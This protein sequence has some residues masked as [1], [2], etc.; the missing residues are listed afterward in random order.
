MHIGG[1]FHRAG[2]VVEGADDPGADD[3]EGQQQSQPE[4]AGEDQRRGEDI[5]L[6]PGK[7]GVEGVIETDG[8][9]HGILRHQMAAGAVCAAKI[10]LG[11]QRTGHH[12]PA[13]HAV[14]HH[15]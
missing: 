10:L 6:D 13:V 15:L 11:Q 9:E 3:P 14:V 7:E 1:F 5:L 2:Q 12:Q 4:D 8:A